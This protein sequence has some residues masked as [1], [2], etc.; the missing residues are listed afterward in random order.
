MFTNFRIYWKKKNINQD[1]KT[2]KPIVVAYGAGKF[3]TN[4]KGNDA[5]PVTAIPKKLSHF[6]N[7]T[8][9]L[10][11]EFNTSQACSSCYS[12]MKRKKMWSY[13]KIYPKCL[14]LKRKQKKLRYIMSYQYKRVHKAC[15]KVLAC[16]KQECINAF[17]I[18]RD[19]NACYNIYQNTKN[20]LQGGDKH[21][22]FKR[23][24]ERMPKP[25]S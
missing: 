11:N 7:V 25:N 5:T 19:V 16:S 20:L 17:G 23:K 9:V 21:P 22:I 1:L 13:Q 12:K 6:P 10:V 24:R 2:G 4:V 15:F 8:V 18:H 14:T 3:K